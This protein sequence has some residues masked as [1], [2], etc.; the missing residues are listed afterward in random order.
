MTRLLPDSTA[1]VDALHRRSAA[2]PEAVL[3]RCLEEAIPAERHSGREK[4][5]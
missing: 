2:P 3:G 1:L 5:P 4:Q